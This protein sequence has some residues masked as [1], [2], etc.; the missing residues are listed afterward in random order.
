VQSHVWRFAEAMTVRRQDLCKSIPLIC[1][2]AAVR[3]MGAF[4]IEPLEGCSLTTTEYPG[5]SS[6]C[7]MIHGCNDPDVSF[8]D[9]LKCPISSNS[10]A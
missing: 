1:I 2:P 8:V 5:H 10:L 3:E 9:W 6:P 7:A 4:V